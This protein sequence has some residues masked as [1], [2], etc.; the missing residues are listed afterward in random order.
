MLNPG[1]VA[2][3]LKVGLM[4]AAVSLFTFTEVG[5]DPLFFGQHAALDVVAENDV[6]I[7]LFSYVPSLISIALVPLW[8]ALT[9]ALA[10]HETSWVSKSNLTAATAAAVIG[11]ASSLVMLLL[12]DPV[13]RVWLGE[14]YL[15]DPQLRCLIAAFIA[16][17]AFGLYQLYVMNALGLVA[18]SAAVATAF[19]VVGLPLKLTALGITRSLSASY[20]ALIVWYLIKIPVCQLLINNAVNSPGGQPPLRV[21]PGHAVGL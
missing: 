4:F 8:P 10:S 14:V 9:A 11:G 3:R 1:G 6:V 18:V 21:R 20:A 16:L 13:L 19:L 12:L 15:R 7:K 2:H 5:L 17:Q